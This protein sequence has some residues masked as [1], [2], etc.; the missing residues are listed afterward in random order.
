V[1]KV[2]Q[3]GVQGHPERCAVQSAQVFTERL[4]RSVANSGNV[5]IYRAYS[6]STSEAVSVRRRWYWAYRSKLEH[7]PRQALRLTSCQRGTVLVAK[8]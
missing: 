2:Q 7:R 4:R 3:L 1:A 5:C 8:G 6:A